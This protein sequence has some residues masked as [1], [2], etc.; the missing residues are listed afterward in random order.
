MSHSSAP[1]HDYS[2]EFAVS[3]TTVDTIIPP[4]VIPHTVNYAPPPSQ[5]SKGHGSA[6][7]A[8]ERL[9]GTGYDASVSDDL[10]PE[11]THARYTLRT[12]PANTF[13]RLDQ[14]F[15]ALYPISHRNTG[16]RSVKGADPRSNYDAQ[17]GSS[18]VRVSGE[19]NSM[20]LDPR[21]KRKKY[22]VLPIPS[23][24]LVNSSDDRA[25]T[26]SSRKSH[27]RSLSNSAAAEFDKPTEAVENEESHSLWQWQNE[28]DRRT[29]AERPPPRIPLPKTPR[30]AVNPADPEDQSDTSGTLH[31]SRSRSGSTTGRPLDYSMQPPPVPHV[32]SRKDQAAT[33]KSANSLPFSNSVNMAGSSASTRAG[34]SSNKTA[35]PG[36]LHS[37]P[38]DTKRAELL[39][40]SSTA[41]A[42][43]TKNNSKSL[44]DLKI[45]AGRRPPK[46]SPGN[47]TQGILPPSS[48]YNT[49][50]ISRR[51]NTNHIGLGFHSILDSR[52]PS[53]PLAV[54]TT[55]SSLPYNQ[56]PPNPHHLQ[57]YPA[58]SPTTYSSI[59]AAIIQDGA[60]PPS[61]AWSPSRFRTNYNDSENLEGESHVSSGLSSPRSG[62]SSRMRLNPTDLSIGQN[63]G[64]RGGLQVNISS[65]HAALQPSQDPYGSP[66][67][68]RSPPRSPSSP[69][70]SHHRPR[71]A[72]EVVKTYM[73][74]SASN[75]SER[76]NTAGDVGFTE[77]ARR[78]SNSGTIVPGEY[79][80][81]ALGSLRPLSIDRKNRT[82]DT[83]A[84]STIVPTDY[85]IGQSPSLSRD[86]EGSN[87]LTF[88]G[89]SNASTHTLVEEDYDDD[90]D[91]DSDDAQGTL[92]ATPPAQKLDHANSGRKSV[93]TSNSGRKP[94]LIV[95]IHSSGPPSS[96]VPP[97]ETSPAN[98]TDTFMPKPHQGSQRSSTF[99]DKEEETWAPR[100]PAEDVYDRLE[101]YFPGH[102]LDMPVIDASSGATSPTALQHHIPPPVPEKDRGERGAIKAKKSIRVVAAE[103]KRR[104]DRTSLADQGSVS[105]KRSTRLWGSKLEEVTL[106]VSKPP[107]DTS[108]NGNKSML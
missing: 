12:S 14:E 97:V 94:D 49:I 98:S 18:N 44:T 4:P 37:P 99:A 88:F 76:P 96:Y 32:T 9:G 71:T 39:P 19:H 42:R 102:D 45:N 68:L 10:D 84:V 50:D 17:E 16:S 7:S 65:S 33:Y 55:Q 11:W 36:W 53:R 69:R 80:G 38:P 106:G 59:S 30:A 67:I 104:I 23:V 25:H 83:E 75:F 92:W 81:L 66:S 87:A 46:A 24:N 63:P 35:N 5:R 72:D 15:G 31:R 105:R 56:S 21:A 54:K 41:W 103:H 13:S 51:D 52:P 86:A 77:R 90:D 95:K 26:S 1:A 57:N 20:S 101:E 47:M 74:A 27:I 43:L 29:R 2:P 58:H 79:T 73:R 107:S 60:R 62:G 108:P 70:Q 89:N 82:V 91:Y 93:R 34:K 6:S 22:V 64:R 100:P 28:N 3:P 61:S 78:T 85:H 8:S 48:T 40:S